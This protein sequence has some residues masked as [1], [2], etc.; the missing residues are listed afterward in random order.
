M[1]KYGA[2]ERIIGIRNF[3]KMDR[4][5][6]EGDA[7]RTRSQ[8]KETSPLP[9]KRRGYENA[10]HY[11]DSGEWKLSEDLIESH[12]DGAVAQR[13]PTKAI[14]SADLN[15]VAV[16]DVLSAD[17]TR[18]RGGVRA[19]QLTDVATGKSLVLATVKKSAPGEL[20]PPNQLV[21]R[22]SFDGLEA[23]TLIVWKHN[24]FSQ[25]LL[26]RERP[27]LPEGMNGAWTRLEVVTEFDW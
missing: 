5:P 10:L 8:T 11:F 18:L 15:A 26:L 27:E 7:T 1:T 3:T 2:H 6:S 25:S 24:S 14:F 17:G 13:G 4:Q 16:F 21:Y 20:A 9:R 23:E 22:D 19:I 12:P